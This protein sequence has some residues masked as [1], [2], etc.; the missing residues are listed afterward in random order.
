MSD[1]FRITI[2]TG[3]RPPRPDSP[4]HTTAYYG[5]PGEEIPDHLP[6]WIKEIAAKPSD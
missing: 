2:G 3:K 4:E 5:L 1:K 6:D